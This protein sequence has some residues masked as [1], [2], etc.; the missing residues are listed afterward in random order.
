[1]HNLIMRVITQG[2]CMC[3]CVCVS[4][5]AIPF[6]SDRGDGSGIL[7]CPMRLNFNQTLF[8]EH[9]RAE[10]HAKKKIILRLF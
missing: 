9:N 8:V 3:V 7:F 5:A 2:V 6:S 1:M 10:Q 4:I